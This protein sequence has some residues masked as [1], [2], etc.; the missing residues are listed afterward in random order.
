MQLVKSLL[1]VSLAAVTSAAAV[2]S[3]HFSNN[4][5]NTRGQC[6]CQADADKLTD[7][8]VRM[9]TKWDDAD[10]KYLSD[11]GFSDY[12]DSINILAG[13]PMGAS[14]FPTK[15]AF[16]DHQHVAVRTS[17]P[18]SNIPHD[19]NLTHQKSPTTSPSP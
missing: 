4:N 3:D 11:S 16:I 13:L 2:A 7:A 9:I 5:L 17:L 19:E 18:A 1:L 6:L 15:Q 14:I 10:A 12:S 8:Y